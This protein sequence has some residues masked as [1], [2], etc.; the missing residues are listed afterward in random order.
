M[1]IQKF[2][3]ILGQ[4]AKVVREDEVYFPV[5]S[6]EKAFDEYSKTLKLKIPIS[7]EDLED[8]QNGKTFDWC[9]EGVDVHLYS[10]EEE[11]LIDDIDN[12]DTLYYCAK[13]QKSFK[14]NDLNDLER[15]EIDNEKSFVCSDC[16]NKEMKEEQ[17]NTLKEKNKRGAKIPNIKTE[18]KGGIK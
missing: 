18:V 1:T 10:A 9:F 17:K 14:Y 13:C 15:E 8:L 7:D 3:K 6:I 12:E 4:Y 2:Q 16:I 11:D 5:S